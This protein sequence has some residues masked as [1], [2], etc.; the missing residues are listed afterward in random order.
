MSVFRVHLGMRDE[1][2]A[3]LAE[4]TQEEIR[5]AL[6]VRY[7][8]QMCEIGEGQGERSTKQ[9]GLGGGSVNCVSGEAY[10][11]T[12]LKWAWSPR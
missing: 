10:P 11:W 7:L 9:D 12:R 3:N 8:I 2:S 4:L 1:Q 6:F 5:R